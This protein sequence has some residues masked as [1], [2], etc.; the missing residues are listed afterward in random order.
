MKATK[1]EEPFW[2]SVNAVFPWKHEKEGEMSAHPKSLIE[3][4][5]KREIVRTYITSSF[6]LCPPIFELLAH[7][8][9]LNVADFLSGCWE[10]E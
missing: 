5:P 7:I 9:H 3:R 4:I 10:R 6:Y 1:A 2:S 8:V